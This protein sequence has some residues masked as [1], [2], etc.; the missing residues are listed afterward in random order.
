[1]REDDIENGMGATAFLIHIGG[2]HSAGFIPLRHQGP[3]VLWVGEETRLES[4]TCFKRSEIL[5]TCAYLFFCKKKKKRQSSK[6][7]LNIA[8]KYKAGTMLMNYGYGKVTC[9]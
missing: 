6:D 8:F 5:H 1:M 3:N 9:F 7:V 2:R 4:Q